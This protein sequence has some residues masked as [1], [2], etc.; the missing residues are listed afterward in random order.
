MLIKY[1]IYGILLKAT[2]GPKQKKRDLT[3]KEIGFNSP[4]I[5]SF[6][7]TNFN[8]IL[9]NCNIVLTNCNFILTN[10]NGQVLS[11]DPDRT[12]VNRSLQQLLRCL[13]EI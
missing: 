7:L 11:A 6:I 13:S 12:V 4:D 1:S 9:T 3:K 2:K 10:C 5:Y 8:V